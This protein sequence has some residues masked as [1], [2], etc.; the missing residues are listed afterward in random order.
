M[1]IEKNH[2]IFLNFQHYKIIN[3]TYNNNWKFKWTQK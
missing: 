3:S 1:I 2:K